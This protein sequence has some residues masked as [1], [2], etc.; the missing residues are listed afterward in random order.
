[1][2]RCRRCR[3]QLKDPDSISCGIGPV[4]LAK[5]GSSGELSGNSDQ[6]ELD[7]SAPE[8]KPLPPRYAGKTLK[9]QHKETM[10][11][12]YRW[13]YDANDKGESFID[14]LAADSH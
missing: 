6:L 13:R 11:I 3:R 8:I 1:M 7:F 5:I 12:I 9:E 4:C 10:R 2:E 14:D